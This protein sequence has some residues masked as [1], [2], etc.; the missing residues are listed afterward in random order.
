MGAALAMSVEI[1]VCSGQ[2]QE[3]TDQMIS[4]FGH[5]RALPRRDGH[6]DFVSCSER[7]TPWPVFRNVYGDGTF[8]GGLFCGRRCLSE[9]DEWNLS[10]Q[11]P[12][13]AG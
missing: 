2:V 5:S 1:R 11:Y 8:S 10:C 12:M 4:S 13:P 7:E 6:G 9:N 3:Q